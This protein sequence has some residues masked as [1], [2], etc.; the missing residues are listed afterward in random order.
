MT[1]TC[2]SEEAPVLLKGQFH[3]KVGEKTFEQPF[4]I[5]LEAGE[6]NEL[7]IEIEDV[8]LQLVMS[9]KWHY[10][11]GTNTTDGILVNLA[12]KCRSE[13]LRLQRTASVLLG[14]GK[15]GTVELHQPDADNLFTVEV[16]ADQAPK[17]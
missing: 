3:G 11:S 13:Q 9:P 8:D 17:D 10:V 1:L 15:K 16:E 4:E 2:L 12:V 7:P 14:Q 5:R 6:K